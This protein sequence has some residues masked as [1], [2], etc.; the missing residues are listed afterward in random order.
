MNIAADGHRDPNP[1]QMMW[2]VSYCKGIYSAQI[3]HHKELTFSSVHQV[4]VDALS[5]VAGPS[6]FFWQATLD[7]AANRETA[8]LVMHSI[9]PWQK[10]P[11]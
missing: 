5:C 1:Y 7:T 2:Q 10:L 11:H 3:M 6:R 8:F 9:L 4:F